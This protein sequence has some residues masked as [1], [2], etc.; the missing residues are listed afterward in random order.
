MPVLTGYDGDCDFDGATFDVEE[1]DIFLQPD[2]DVKSTLGIRKAP[3]GDRTI[4]QDL[5]QEAAELALPIIVYTE[6]IPA[7]KAKRGQVGTLTLTDG[8]A[9]GGVLFAG[10]TGIRHDY[11][12][13][14]SFATA[15][16]LGVW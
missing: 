8:P 16:F 13:G 6:D 1:N 2:G 10:L 15:T 14:V 4:V 3:W 7:L 11:E 9:R 12:H 5:G